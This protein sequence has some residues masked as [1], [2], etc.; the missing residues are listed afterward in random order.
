MHNT[1]TSLKTSCATTIEENI[2]KAIVE[3]NNATITISA[4]DIL[5]SVGDAF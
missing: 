1:N 2:Y 3:W 4:A 5:Q